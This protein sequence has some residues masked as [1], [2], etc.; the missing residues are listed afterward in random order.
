[1][2]FTDE[3]HLVFKIST[4]V[5]LCYTVITA[6]FASPTGDILETP[7][8]WLYFFAILHFFVHVLNCCE[9]D[10]VWQPLICIITS[11]CM[12]ACGLLM[13]FFPRGLE[14]QC[15][16]FIAP[17]CFGWDLIEKHPQVFGALCTQIMM[18][19][20]SAV[21]LLSFVLLRPCLSSQQEQPEEPGVPLQIMPA[22]EAP[23]HPI[24]FAPPDLPPPRSRWPYNFLSQLRGL[25]PTST[26]TNT[27]PSESVPEE[28]SPDES[29]PDGE[30][31]PAIESS[32]LPQDN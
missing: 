1:M 17:D 19:F 31:V 15:R 7:Y 9:F 26:A 11:I 21:F 20:G 3:E 27:S 29:S 4:L 32:Y 28:Q 12:A 14:L 25:D 13:L 22:I 30:P 5:I 18:Q 2:R 24:A 10:T 23:F 8:F 16:G 6:L